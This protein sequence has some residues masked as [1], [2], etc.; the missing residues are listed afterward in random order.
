VISFTSDFIPRLVYLYMYSPNGTMHGFVNHTLSSFNV[1]DFQ[2]GT[3]PSDPLGL[4]YE[5]QI[6][7]Y[8]PAALRGPHLAGFQENL[9]LSQ[10]SFRD[11]S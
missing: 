3:A 4:G 6:C 11:K 1:S 8:P 9:S 10:D 7:R 5:V 2:N